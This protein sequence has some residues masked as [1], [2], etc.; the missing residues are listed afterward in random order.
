MKML[1]VSDLHGAMDVLKKMILLENPSVV[2]GVGDIAEYWFDDFIIPT[3]A[4]I[5]NHERWLMVNH[6]R[7]YQEL[8]ARLQL[9]KNLNVLETG[10]IYNIDIYKIVGLNGNFTT[11]INESWKNAIKKL[12][13]RKIKVD[14][15]LSHEPPLGIADLS[16]GKHSGSRIARDAL[17]LLKPRFM[18][19]GHVHEAQAEIHDETLVLT[20]GKGQDGCYAT[21]YDGNIKIKQIKMET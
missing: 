15:L 13:S 19:C 11:S 8:K 4:V 2:L 3:Y 21:F 17:E 18:I 6:V 14:F 12:R 16:S 10:K 5:G 1:F 20:L 9:I 7:N